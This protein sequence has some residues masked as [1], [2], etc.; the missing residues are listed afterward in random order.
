MRWTLRKCYERCCSPNCCRSD[1]HP[2]INI[3]L[4]AIDWVWHCEQCNCLRSRNSSNSISLSARSCTRNK[5]VSFSWCITGGNNCKCVLNVLTPDCCC[6]NRPS[7]FNRVISSLL[8]WICLPKHSHVAWCER[9]KIYW[10]AWICRSRN[11]WVNYVILSA[12]CRIIGKVC[13]DL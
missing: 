13:Y 4:S 6:W 7:N 1:Y 10:F 2:V 11:H 8:I 5:L 9:N 12:D 3:C